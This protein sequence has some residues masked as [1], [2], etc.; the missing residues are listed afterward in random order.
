MLLYLVVVVSVLAVA[1]L[2]GLVGLHLLTVPSVGISART[3]DDYPGM[4]LDAADVGVRVVVLETR[5][6]FPLTWVD[7][8]YTIELPDARFSLSSATH[9]EL[10][11]ALRAAGVDDATWGVTYFTPGAVVGAE[12][13][14]VFVLTNALVRRLTTLEAVVTLRDGIGRSITKTIPALPKQPMGRPVTAAERA[15]RTA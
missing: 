5:S 13:S 7:A 15:G 2:L 11:D 4:L 9:R 8:H 1:V 10:V 14:T 3:E 12:E 6:P